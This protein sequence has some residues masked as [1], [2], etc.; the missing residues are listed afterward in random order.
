MQAKRWL[1]A[2][3][4]GVPPA[5]ALVQTAEKERLEAE[6]ADRQAAIASAQRLLRHLTWEKGEV[7]ARGASAAVVPSF[8]AVY[9]C[10]AYDHRHVRR[11]WKHHMCKRW[12]WLV[13]Q[14]CERS[15]S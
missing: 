12:W 10:V 4:P 14:D 1:A 8:G 11:P 5:R 15:A 6:L 2:S 7:V 3:R 9:W 13:T